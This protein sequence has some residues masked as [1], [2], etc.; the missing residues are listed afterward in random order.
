LIRCRQCQSDNPDDGQF[1]IVCGQALAQTGGRQS[2]IALP[3][4]SL[5]QPVVTGL[6]S[7]HPA[8]T[9]GTATAASILGWIGGG[10]MA[11]ALLLVAI[12]IA[13]EEVAIAGFGFLL[14]VPGLVIALV[15]MIL[16]A[17]ALYQP[18]T[19]ATL[20]GRRRAIVGVVAGLVTFVICCL[21]TYL[22]T[23]L[24]TIE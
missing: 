1:C 22:T 15:G 16:G 24:P 20:Q 4:I 13:I 23:Q 2:D 6:P 10:M 12:S 19:A 17:V 8:K 18:A 21:I 11:L 5:H 9:T 3:T 14:S 7:G